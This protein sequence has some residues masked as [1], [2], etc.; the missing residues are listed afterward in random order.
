MPHAAVP[1][2][3]PAEVIDRHW[4]HPL[5]ASVATADRAVTLLSFQTMDVASARWI[6]CDHVLSNPSF[7]MQWR[8]TA[9][10]RLAERH[11]G[12]LEDFTAVPEKTT[13][14]YVMQW[15]LVIPTYLGAVLFHS[16]RRV[17]SLAPQQLGFRLDP[18]AERELQEVALRPGRFWCL[19]DDPDAEHP[20][21]IPV[22]DEAALGAVLRREV[23]AHATRFLA[24]YDPQVR[25]GRRTQWAT[26]TDVLDSG[27]LLAG[28][29][30]GSPQAG[31]ADARL[32][33]A[34][35]EKP[36]TSPS[37]ICVVTDERGRTHWT[38]RRGSCCFLYALPGI[39]RPCAS[40]PRVSEA[41]RV[42]I[43]STLHRA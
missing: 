6:T 7:F 14:G 15:Y 4:T 25:F 34:G 28:R 17:P 9:A 12:L 43:F 10:Q 42:R 35:G 32:V 23:I 8:I 36:L 2:G 38:R 21:A 16:A 11:P 20:D 3:G 27:L 19:P 5:V 31:A 24:V 37:T 22:P 29:S 18:S 33:L 13:A 39:E 26:V 40:C 1:I 30:F 41:E